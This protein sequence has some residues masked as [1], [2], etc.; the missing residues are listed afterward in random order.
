MAPLRRHTSK[1]ELI[2][3]PSGPRSVSSELV[4]GA[5]GGSVGALVVHPIDTVKTRLQAGQPVSGFVRRYGAAG[6]YRGIGV[7]LISQPMY[8]GA[9]LGGLQAG[10]FFAGIAGRL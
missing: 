6:L 3:H 1:A 9:A 7:P 8:I 2:V 10:R 5:V 4:C